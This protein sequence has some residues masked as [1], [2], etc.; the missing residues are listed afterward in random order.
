M[1][2]LKFIRENI[3]LVRQNI[4]NKNEKANV[5]NIIN[6]DEKRRQNIQT[7][8]DLKN[9]RNSVSKEISALIS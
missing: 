7:A 6:L 8:Q 9:L 2:D 1:L 3:E 4:I 5:D